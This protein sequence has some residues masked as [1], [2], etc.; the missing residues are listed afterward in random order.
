[1]RQRITYLLPGD[2]EINP[3]DIKF[4]EKELLYDYDVAEE[5][6]ITLG[7]SD[8]PL[9]VCHVMLMEWNEMSQR[10]QLGEDYIQSF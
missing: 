1:M 9:E 8:L 3:A 6:R 4:D 2:H 7:L 10:P 5:R